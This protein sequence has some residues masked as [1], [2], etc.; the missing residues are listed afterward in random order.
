MAAI[1]YDTLVTQIKNTMED[2][3]TEFDT[4]IPNFI[5]RAELTLT[6]TL[7]NE[8]L[9]EYATSQYTASDAFLTLPAGTLIIKNVN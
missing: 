5:R 9:T 4:A 2:D 8:G 3:G 7:D 6:N 1:T